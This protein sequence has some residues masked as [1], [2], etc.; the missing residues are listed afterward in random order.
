MRLWVLSLALLTGLRIWH[1]RELW[2][3]LQTWLGSCVAVA[4][5]Q[6]G[7]YSSDSTPSLGT[8]ICHRKQP[9]KRQKDNNNKKDS[10]ILSS[11]KMQTVLLCKPC[12]EL[13]K[14]SRSK[15]TSSTVSA[16]Q[17]VLSKCLLL[18][19]NVA[20]CIDIKRL[21]FFFILPCLNSALCM[22]LFYFIMV[23]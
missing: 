10:F 2:S 3:R 19:Q 21:L 7:G 8:F 16:V 5:V 9:Q 4:V 23:N 12:V 18:S 20:R 11:Q 13:A 15:E 22:K 17:Q 6:A 14:H 1:C